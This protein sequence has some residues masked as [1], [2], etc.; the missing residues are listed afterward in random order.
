M[1]CQHD[2]RE[3]HPYKNCLVIDGQVQPV[4]DYASLETP[5]QLLPKAYRPNGA[6]YCMRSADFLE[7]Q[8]FFVPPCVPYVMNVEDSVDIDSER[9]LAIA[10]QMLISKGG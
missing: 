5:R 2:G 7:K 8:T 10:E 4:H 6:I 1:C 9:D 3:H